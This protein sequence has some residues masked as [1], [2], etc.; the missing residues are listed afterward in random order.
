MRLVSQYRRRNVL[1]NFLMLQRMRHNV[2]I[3]VTTIAL[4]ILFL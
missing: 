4:G 2:K 3:I 1:P